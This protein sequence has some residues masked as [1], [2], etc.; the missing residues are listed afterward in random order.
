MLH[1]DTGNTGFMILCTSLV[2]LMTPGLA[3][4]YGGL[5][6]RKNVL[7]I[8]IQS[9]VSMGWTTVIWYVYGYSLCFSGDW[10]GII[11]NFH[12]AFLRGINLN[13]PSP[14]HTH[15]RLR[16][17]RLPDDV[18]HHHA[19]THLGRVHQSR[20]LQGLH[21]V[22]DRMADLR[23]L[24]LRSHGVGR[25]VPAAVGREG[26]RRRH[27]GAQ[28]RRNRGPG[29]GAS[30]WA[31]GASPDRGPHSIP[32]VALGT[33]LLWFGWYGFNAG[34]EMRVDSVTATAFLNT[35]VAA[36]FAA[37][38]WLMV[39]WLNEKKP[40]FLGLLTGAVAG[41]ATVTPAA[42]YVS[43]T[44]AVII[45]IVSGVVCYYAVEMK[46]K[47]GW[48]DALDVWGVHGVGGF[49]GIVMLGIFAN[50]AIQSR[51]RKWIALWRSNVSFETSHSGRV[52]VG[53]GVRI[54]LR[55]A[56]HHRCLHPGEGERMIGGDWAWMSRSTAST[57]TNSSP[58][59]TWF[60]R[61]SDV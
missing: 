9:F 20:H 50:K 7:A 28:H 6:G 13:T 11:G 2:M 18:R 16:L 41:L 38:A 44:T 10:H 39:A 27:R 40:K 22:S 51:R 46:N 30:T 12:N 24:P 21:A 59:K 56:T 61:V 23:L 58:M 45:G 25:R 53:L 26:F 17:H 15:S 34:S 1:L 32:L 49:L 43:P 5:V 14:N 54:H 60:T 57:P 48:D 19:G 8:M 37:V 31:S 55:H 52:L 3:F 42:G 47:L 4:F 33:G 36:S 35:D 29:L